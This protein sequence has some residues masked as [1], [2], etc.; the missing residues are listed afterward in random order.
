MGYSFK[1][2]NTE[3]DEEQ[4]YRLEKIRG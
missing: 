1:N 4:L 2:G 3:L